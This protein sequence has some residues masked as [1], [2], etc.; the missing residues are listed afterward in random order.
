MGADYRQLKKFS[1]RLNLLNSKHFRRF[2]EG[3][4]RELAT[5]LL[6]KAIPRTPVDTGTLRRG[7]TAKTHQEAESGA[8]E[9]DYVK[10]ANSLPVT[11]QGDAYVIKIINPVEYAAY[12]EFGHRTRTGKGWVEGRFMLTKSEMELEGELDKIIEEKMLRFFKQLFK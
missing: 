9:T 2:I 8:G 4:S 12:V 3:V 10:Y 6:G 11:K 5:R 7:W 1:E